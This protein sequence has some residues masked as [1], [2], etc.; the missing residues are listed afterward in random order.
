MAKVEMLPLDQIGF[1]PEYYPRVNGKADWLNINKYKEALKTHPE[2]A[3]YRREGAFPPIVVV[4]AT[5]YDWQYLTLDGVHR[6]S[7]F[8][9]AGLDK[10]AAVVEHIPQSKWL[11]RSAEL[12][13]DGK[14]PL[15]SGDKRWVASKLLDQG[16]EKEKISELLCMEP[17][18]FERLMATNIEK[19]TAASSKSIP[20]GR[21]NRQVGKNHIGFLKAPF[22]SISGTANAQRAL[23]SQQSVSAMESAQIIESFIALLESRAMD[24]HDEHVVERLRKAGELLD[25][26]LA[27]A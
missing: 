16:F 27:A 8:A 17:A 5:G 21:A 4:K 19:L 20:V 10:I 11:A 13:V 12:N 22:T 26:L 25:K 1:D 24:T 18:S 14:M 3:D 15:G 23:A 7:A 2:K 9:A 6:Q